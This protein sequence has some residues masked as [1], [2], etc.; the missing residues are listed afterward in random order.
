MDS[1]MLEVT[2]ADRDAAG[3]VDPTNRVD[4]K[5]GRMDGSSTV[6]AFA[7]HR[8]QSEGRTGEGEREAIVAWLRQQSDKGADI[9]LEMNKGS[10]AR[11]AYGGGSFALKRAADEIEAGAHIISGIA[12]NIAAGLTESQSTAGEGGA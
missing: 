9:A 1:T 11:S 3:Q 4:Y 10:T 8:I 12:A 6:Q 2:Q 5:L 7:R